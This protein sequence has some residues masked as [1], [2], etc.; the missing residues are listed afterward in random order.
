MSTDDFLSY[1]GSP[2]TSTTTLSTGSSSSG[3]PSR[4]NH[5]GAIAGGVVGGVAALIILAGLTLWLLRR[6]KN[7]HMRQESY[8]HVYHD[9]MNQAPGPRQTPELADEQ[10]RRE[11]DASNRHM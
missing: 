5:V 6:K 9:D 3:S 7:G 8:P 10:A 1:K 4:S 11:L 2:T